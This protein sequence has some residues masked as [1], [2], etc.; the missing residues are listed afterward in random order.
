MKSNYPLLRKT[1][2]AIIALFTFSLCLVSFANAT[3]YYISPT[4]NDAT[5]SGT[6]ANPWRTLAK[7]TATVTTA[8]NIIHVNA[9]TYPETQQSNLA[10]GVSIEGDGITSLITSTVGGA[11]DGSFVPTISLASSVVQ[12]GNQH[13]S[14]IKLDGQMASS[15]AIWVAYRNNVSVYNCTIT[16]F[17]NFGVSFTNTNDLWTIV[18]P[19]SYRTG[20][21][22]HDNIV[23]NCANYEGWGR[24]CLNIGGQTGMLVY[25]NTIVQNSR[26]TGHN[27][28]PIK[29]ANDGFTRGLKIYNN[30]LTKNLRVLNSND[31]SFCMEIF[32][33]QGTEIY[34]NTMQGSMD[35]NFQGDK[36][37]YP[38]VVYIHD[39][40]CSIPAVGNGVQ[41][42][43]I[44]EYSADGLIIENNVFNNLSHAIC[45][46][47]RAGA[48]I[49]DVYIRKNLVSNLGSTSSSPV[50]L[51]GFD[52]N[53][54]TTRNFNILN[55]TVSND[56]IPNHNSDFMMNFTGGGNYVFDSLIIKNNIFKGFS[57]NVAFIQDI[58]KFKHSEFSFNDING[59]DEYGNHNNTI[60]TPTWGTGYVGY[61]GT[62]NIH[63]NFAGV[64]PRFA[65]AG[66][67]ALQ[68]TSPL[69]D[70][71]TN[72]GLTYAGTAPDQGYVELGTI[73]LPVKL[74]DFSATENKGKNLLHWTTATENNSD[75]FSIERSSDG[76]HFD[77]IG[78]VNAAGF[79]TTL[80]NYS[81]TD[82]SPLPGVNYYRLITI[83][84]DNSKDYSNTVSVTNKKEQS[85]SI[86]T[87]EIA[88]SK[89][90]MALNV[91][92]SQN[93][94][95]TIAVFD[96][97]GRVF[98]NEPVQLQKGVT[99]INKHTAVLSAGIYYIRLTTTDETVVRNVFTK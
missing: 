82:L 53:D 10:I 88:I 57:S 16:N 47:P 99:T 3:T 58:T 80:I 31:W 29:Y 45:F 63:N 14:N 18:A 67:Y 56:T 78:K 65:G 48:T 96:V 74:T 42:A 26:P 8:G 91:V 90:N 98:F 60:W 40:V 92:S 23:T 32:N 76:Q 44:M 84:K 62:I 87:A 21:S 81:F 69:I 66:N 19:T 94:K 20:N 61:P 25:N 97:N 34:G 4:G 11:T 68:P 64:E 75:Y 28:W 46:Y 70:A 71:G 89:S 93:Q 2:P 41:E 51:F 13:I 38:Y 15:W 95:A 59:K 55:N 85:L 30:T 72:V 37:T 1:V 9:G 6:L 86:A 22:F 5:G 27:G 43:V 24:G 33:G 35:F 50:F 12:D 83:D 54:V 17:Y 77:A 36:G 39:N 73:I 52:A 7:A 79:S 49:K